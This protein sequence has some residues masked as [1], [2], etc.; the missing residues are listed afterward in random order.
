VSI[1]LSYEDF[2]SIASVST[3]EDFATG[4]R[5]DKKGVYAIR[6]FR[7]ELLTETEH[8]SL[9]P[10]NGWE[11]PMLRFPCSPDEMRSFFD[12]SCL[13]EYKESLD[14]FIKRHYPCHEETLP[15]TPGMLPIIAGKEIIPVRLI[16]LIANAGLGQVTLAGILANEV[17]VNGFPYLA[18]QLIKLTAYNAETGCS[19]PITKTR[20]ELIGNL[21][22]KVHAYHLNDDGIPVIMRS[23][24]WKAIYREVSVL[25]PVLRKTEETNGVPDSME[26]S[27]RLEATKVL[28]PGVF[29]YR[30]DFELLFQK[31]IG[32]FV[33]RPD[34]D[35]PDFRKINYSAYIRP[36]Y[37]SLIWEGLGHLRQA[38]TMAIPDQL[39]YTVNGLAERWK[40]KFTKDR[41]EDYLYNG[42]LKYTV[43]LTGQFL[44]YKAENGERIPC[45]NV[46]RSKSFIDPRYDEFIIANYYCVAP[47]S[48]NN[49]IDLGNAK[50]LRFEND[51]CWYIYNIIMDIPRIGKDD[52]FISKEEIERFES[53]APTVNEIDLVHDEPVIKTEALPPAKN[54]RITHDNTGSRH[55][56]S[57]MTAIDA[58]LQAFYWQHG[59]RKPGKP[60]G[61]SAIGE[62]VDFID[63]RYKAR[64]KD[65]S[66]PNDK[67]MEN[68]IDLKAKARGDSKQFI[69][70]KAKISDTNRNGKKWHPWKAFETQFGTAMKNFTPLQPTDE[71]N[72]P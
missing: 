61:K 28:P 9:R 42:Q 67:F 7:P 32:S 60:E 6:P 30:D 71:K 50:L 13:G 11:E 54:K 40:G 22:N 70:L 65:K 49:F 27:W 63:G 69:R 10:C 44:K 21:D 26:A 68:I 56:F 62:F 20:A 3:P 1:K 53:I 33:T 58:C 45:G 43:R 4:L 19:E 17:R 66:E 39:L 18:Q 24:E 29:L 57:L 38:R 64:L 55:P 25:E 51:G 47:D 12:D 36:E 72:N 16:P 41:I 14:A 31:H 59:E 8:D 23:S 46:T 15:P 2:I 52:L 48:Q 35:P 34:Y 5:A 37:K